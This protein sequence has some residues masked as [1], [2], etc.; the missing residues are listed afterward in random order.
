M[1]R[2]S[3]YAKCP[4]DGTHAGVYQAPALV[5][6]VCMFALGGAAQKTPSA[7]ATY[8]PFIAAIAMMKHSVGSLNCLVISDT[9]PK[10]LKSMGSAFLISQEADFLTAAHVVIAMQGTDDSCP[11]PAI[12]LAAHDWRPD[13]PN[14]E[15]LWFP[16]RTTDCW[17]DSTVDVA[18]CRPS[19]DF[20]ARI[21]ILHKAVPV[22]IDSNIQPDGTQVAF[23]G[24]PLQARDP[25]TL[26]AHVA[27]YQV[28]WPD[29]A[30]PQ[31][32]LDHG[33]LP[34]FSGSPVFRVD[35][36]VIAI[37]VR[38]GSPDAPGTS[39]ARPVSV[40]RE[41]LGR[42]NWNQSMSKSRLVH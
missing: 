10:I 38:D 5:A 32:V 24:F 27:A 22:Q 12:T 21:R 6:Y 39:V 36:K 16:F 7:A 25:M 42:P 18:K 29:E 19:G 41:M 23:S 2:F 8:D 37:L 9:K 34:G 28:P 31:V 30:T 17:V 26:R 15:L 40:F 13:A 3:K 33:A 35:G 4:R 14:E 11:I 1:E 20:P